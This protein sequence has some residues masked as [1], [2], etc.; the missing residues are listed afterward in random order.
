MRVRFILARLPSWRPNPLHVLRAM[1]FVMGLG[2]GM[3]V[4]LAL[5]FVLSWG[6]AHRMTSPQASGWRTAWVKSQPGAQ[7]P[8]ALA[9]VSAQR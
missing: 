3:V 9:K 8:Q 5:G 6:L 7:P 4:G 1:R 2:W